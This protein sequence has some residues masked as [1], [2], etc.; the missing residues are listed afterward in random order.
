MYPIYIAIKKI[1]KDNN[2]FRKTN[3][4]VRVIGSFLSPSL[5]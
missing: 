5:L 2:K 1:K 4:L 3:S